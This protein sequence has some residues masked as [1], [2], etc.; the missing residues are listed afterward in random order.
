M[1]LNL[2]YQIA[3]LIVRE[4]EN[5]KFTPFS[6]TENRKLCVYCTT[7][8]RS[9]AI[10]PPIGALP[11]HSIYCSRQQNKPDSLKLH[12]FSKTSSPERK[13]QRYDTIFSERNSARICFFSSCCNRK[14]WTFACIALSE[15]RD[16]R[17]FCA[18]NGLFF[19]SF[20][21]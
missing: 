19:N 14:N 21:P 16:R 9:I 3:S 1:L 18:E 7:L 11:A 6:I 10:R 17:A 8:C 2:D 12:I 15:I 4:T 5:Q 20:S 13:Q